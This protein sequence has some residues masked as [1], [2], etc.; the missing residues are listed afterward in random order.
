MGWERYFY[1]IAFILLS[2]VIRSQVALNNCDQ[3]G[4]EKQHPYPPALRGLAKT[5]S[6]KAASKH[7]GSFL[8]L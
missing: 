3:S 6:E 8:W 1:V 4:S 5:S 7:L 2:P